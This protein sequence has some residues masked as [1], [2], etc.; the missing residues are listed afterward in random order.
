MHISI[1]LTNVTHIIRD[2]DFP[3]FCS[4]STRK[5]LILPAECSPP[6]SLILLEILPA[7][8]IQAKR[9]S[10]SIADRKEVKIVK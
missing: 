3:S 2:T 6:K 1:F 8:F 9:T 7:E 5:C 4:N 10:K